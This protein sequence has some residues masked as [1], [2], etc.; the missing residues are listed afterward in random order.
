MAVLSVI[1]RLLWTRVGTVPIGLILRYAGFFCYSRNKSIVTSLH[2]ILPMSIKDLTALAGW[3][4]M[5]Q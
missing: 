2:G 1:V 5:F 4:M 3:L